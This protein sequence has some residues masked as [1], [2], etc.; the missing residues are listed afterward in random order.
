MAL[1]MIKALLLGA[2]AQIKELDIDISAHVK[3]KGGEFPT[4]A[5]R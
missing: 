3:H 4:R 5:Q 2:L 1:P